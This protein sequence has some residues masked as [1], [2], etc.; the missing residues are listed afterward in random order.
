[1][2][3]IHYKQVDSG[4]S[5]LGRLTTPLVSRAVWK[6]LASLCQPANP[7]QP[8][9]PCATKDFHLYQQK[10]EWVHALAP[11]AEECVKELYGA[12]FMPVPSDAAEGKGA[13]PNKRSD[14]SSSSQNQRRWS[15]I[16]LC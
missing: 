10:E 7:K 15:G 4:S 8:L 11:L 2:Q 1:M 3:D 14:F 12:I 6:N 5:R 16:S 13:D 9:P